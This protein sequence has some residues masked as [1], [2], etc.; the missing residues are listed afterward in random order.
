MGYHTMSDAIKHITDDIFSFS[1][2]VYWCTCIV[3]ATQ[4]NCC[5]ALDFLSPEPCPPTARPERLDYNK[6]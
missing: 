4:S 3:R 1:N 2:S 5:A 6:I